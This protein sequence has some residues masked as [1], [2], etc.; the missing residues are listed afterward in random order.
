VVLEARAAIVDG[1]VRRHQG[2][3][4]EGQAMVG[5]NP[6][7]VP[8]AVEYKDAVGRLVSATSR[9]IG[10]R[11][12]E[13]ADGEVR[14][15]GKRVMIKGVNRHE[16]DPVTYRVM[17]MESMRKDIELMKQANVNAVRTSHYPNDPRW[18]DLADEYGL[19]VMD[20]ANIESH[21]YMERATSAGDPQKREPPSSLATR[22]T[23]KSPTWTACRAWSSATRTTRRSSSGRWGMKPAPGRISRTPPTGSARTTRRACSATS[24]TACWAKHQP[25]AYVDIYAPMYDDIEKMVDY[26][27]TRATAAD[28][29]VRIRACD[30]QFAGQPGRL[31]AGHPG[32]KKLQGGFI[33]DWV[34]QSVHAKDSKGRT[35]W[36]SGFDMNP[37]RGDNSVVGDGVVGS[38]RTPDPEYYELQKVYSPVV[39]EGDPKSGKLTRVNRYDFRDLSGLDFDW[40][41]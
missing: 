36:A 28:D 37:E 14:V 13:I 29:P 3:H 22:S 17:S 6:E 40:S 15:N 4:P 39:F 9:R 16:H 8:H 1:K 41:I 7:P 25:N 23:G 10:F 26:A 24:A 5:R 35:Y 18:Y 33:W 38:D 21:G 2:R 31:L 32:H 12:V 34:D 30:G 27:P 19:Y 11:T 20:E